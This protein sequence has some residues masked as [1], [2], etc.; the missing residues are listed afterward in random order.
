M[1]ESAIA[2][3]GWPQLLAAVILS[4]W[5]LAWI[6]TEYGG[7]RWRVSGFFVGWQ[8]FTPL[9]DWY[10]D[11]PALLLCVLLMELAYRRFAAREQQA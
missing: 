2:V 8:A 6:P 3:G 11:L 5:L 9:M 10:V 7:M 4:A 1:S